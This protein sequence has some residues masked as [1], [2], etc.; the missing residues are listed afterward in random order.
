VLTTDHAGQ[1]SLRFNGVD[2]PGRGDY[3][4]YYGDTLNGTYLDPSPSLQPLIDTGNVRFSYQDSAIRTW[5]TDTSDA[6]KTS[7]AE[8]MA[9]LPDVI[10]TY[11]LDGDRYRR[12]TAN[13]AAMTRRERRWWRQH[14]QELV[15][16]MAAR[17]SADVVGLLRDNA[18]Y[19]AAGD[20]GGAQEPVQRIPIVFAGAGIGKRDSNAAM[21]S[22][23][24]LPTIL[25]Q[26]R[27][28]PRPDLD[29]AAERLPRR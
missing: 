13:P 6:A 15:D 24:I 16:T 27:I 12:V 29:G 17:Y 28:A 1:P 11:A 5:L 2:G 18:N 4:W 8:V 9:T 21:R 3:N 19:G 14:A 7:A 25:R 20:H 26:M 22:V 10:A 23:D